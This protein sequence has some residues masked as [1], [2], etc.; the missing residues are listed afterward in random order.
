MKI[1]SKAEF[2]IKNPYLGLNGV[3]HKASVTLQIDYLNKN[4]SILPGAGHRT[5]NDFTFCV[6]SNR[7]DMWKAVL[8]CIEEAIDIAND[9]L[10]NQE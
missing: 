3:E 4:Y 10:Q 2:V 9:E 1:K 8:K 6:S 5:K 7:N